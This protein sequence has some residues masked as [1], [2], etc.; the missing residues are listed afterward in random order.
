[1]GTTCRVT[2][3]LQILAELVSFLLRVFG[4][5]LS[6]LNCNKEC[7]SAGHVNN[8]KRR[9]WIIILLNLKI[10]SKIGDSFV[11]V[12]ARHDNEDQMNGGVSYNQTNAPFV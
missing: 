8:Q 4:I 2:D 7:N 3:R 10:C 12:A 5:R 11:S 1:M 6:G 9:M